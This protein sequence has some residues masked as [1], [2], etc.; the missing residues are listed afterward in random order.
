MTTYGSIMENQNAQLETTSNRYAR[1]LSHHNE[2]GRAIG[3]VGG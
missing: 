3:G 2:Y 1:V